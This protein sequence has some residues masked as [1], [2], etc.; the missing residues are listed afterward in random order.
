MPA[1]DITIFRISVML[2]E[3]STNDGLKEVEIVYSVL[4][5]KFLEYLI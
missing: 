1:S 2:K 4:K 5:L 3:E